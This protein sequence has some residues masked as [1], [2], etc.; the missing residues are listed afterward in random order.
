M[1]EEG[2]YLRHRGLGTAK[3]VHGD[4]EKQR[5]LA[6]ARVGGRAGEGLD[7]GGRTRGEG[8]DGGGRSL[9]Q[10]EWVRA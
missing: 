8:R 10:G 2:G 6:A 9:E 7:V 5:G 1:G 4:E 3:G